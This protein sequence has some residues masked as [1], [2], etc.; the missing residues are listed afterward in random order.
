[1]DAAGRA[2]LHQLFCI[3]GEIAIASSIVVRLQVPAD[4][5][6]DSNIQNMKPVWASGMKLKGGGPLEH[7]AILIEDEA[8]IEVDLTAL[9]QILS[10]NNYGH[11]EVTIGNLERLTI[12]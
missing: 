10:K 2:S 3:F 6:V 9:D 8:V 12:W 7:A 1:L 11:G 5:V 4:D